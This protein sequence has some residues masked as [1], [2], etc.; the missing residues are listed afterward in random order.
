MSVLLEFIMCKIKNTKKS[1]TILTYIN[2]FLTCM[3]LLQ[4]S[5]SNYR[6]NQIERRII[7][8]NSIMYHIDVN[9]TIRPS[10]FDSI[11][12]FRSQIDNLSVK[13]ISYRNIDGK[14]CIEM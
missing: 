8:K 9:E 3:F 11:K 4:I 12:K 10:T 1:F 2:L 13:K 6:T 5:I 7:P 14:F